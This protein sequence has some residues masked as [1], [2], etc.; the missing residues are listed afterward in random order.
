MQ[1]TNHSRF[2]KF[3]PY[4]VVILLLILCVMFAYYAFIFN[5]HRQQLIQNQQTKEQQR[6]EWLNSEEQSKTQRE[7]RDLQ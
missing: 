6:L 4:V 3:F 7:I 5:P 1:Q 2:T